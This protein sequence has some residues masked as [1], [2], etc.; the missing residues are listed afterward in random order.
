MLA[1]C[2]GIF[3]VQIREQCAECGVIDVTFQCGSIF[4]I[5]TFVVDA[6]RDFVALLIVFRTAAFNGRFPFSIVLT[7]LTLQVDNACKYQCKNILFAP[8]YFSLICVC[9]S[10]SFHVFSLILTSARY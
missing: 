10:V 5:I 6:D 3:V 9:L 4:V 2:V 7:T 8:M 1:Y